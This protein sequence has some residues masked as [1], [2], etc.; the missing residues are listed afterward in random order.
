MKHYSYPADH[1]HLNFN[2]KQD[3]YTLYKKIERIR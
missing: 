1:Y 3:P 2:E